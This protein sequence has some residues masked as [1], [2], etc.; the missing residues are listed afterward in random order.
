ELPERVL[1]DLEHEPYAG[2][3][4][5][6]RSGQVHDERVA[7]DAGQS[8][9]EHAAGL[10]S[11]GAAAQLFGDAG[12][13]LGEDRCGALGGAVAWRDAGSAGGDDE[14]DAALQRLAQGGSDRLGA[15]GD[16]SR[17]VAVEAGRTE[18]GDGDRTG[19]VRAFSA[20]RAVGDGDDGGCQRHAL[21]LAI[22]APSP[23]RTPKP[24]QNHPAH[25]PESASTTNVAS[26]WKRV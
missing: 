9:R 13:L 7:G 16:D 25:A 10:L 23:V 22:W 11:G 8:A 17:V 6:R 2:F 1:R 3:D 24:A 12:Q 26:S 5:G 21:S 15:V 20:G 4:S 14:P 18:G 19:R